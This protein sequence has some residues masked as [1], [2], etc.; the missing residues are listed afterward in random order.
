MRDVVL[1]ERGIS[2]SQEI[3]KLESIDKAG[4]GALKIQDRRRGGL[5]QVTERVRPSFSTCAD[6]GYR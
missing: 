4:S 5:S 1:R 2:L 3:K 6:M